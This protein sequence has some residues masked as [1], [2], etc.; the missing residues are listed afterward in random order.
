[1]K[2]SVVARRLLV[3]ERPALSIH[4]SYFLLLP[5]SPLQH[6]LLTVYLKHEKDFIVEYKKNTSVVLFAY[7]FAIR[8]TY[9][10]SYPLPHPLA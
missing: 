4:T 7:W 1:M 2:M 10:L 6:L 8:Q 9:L 3:G 5:R